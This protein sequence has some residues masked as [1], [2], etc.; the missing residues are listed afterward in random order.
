M[1]AYVR[2]ASECHHVIQSIGVPGQRRQLIYEKGLCPHCQ[3]TASGPR[4]DTAGSDLKQRDLK[5]QSHG[6]SGLRAPNDGQSDRERFA[7]TCGR[8]LPGVCLA[9]KHRV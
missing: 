3:R 1:R 7:C 8:G 6:D 9:L 2:I 4:A 5:D